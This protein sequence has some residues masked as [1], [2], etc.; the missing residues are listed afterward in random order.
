MNIIRTTFDWAGTLY[1][2]W[3]ADWLHVHFLIRTVL[4]LLAVWLIIFLSAQLLHYVIIPLALMAY[5]HGI[6]RAWNFLFVETPQEWLYLRY[7]SKDDHKHASLYSRLCDTVKK[8]RMILSHTKYNGMIYRARKPAT[9]LMVICLVTS[10]L[11]LSAFGLHQEY[12]TPVL[13]IVDTGQAPENNE[14]AAPAPAENEEYPDENLIETEYEDIELEPEIPD[15]YPPGTVS[16][17]SW[18]LDTTI[19]LSL[20]E[21]GTQGARLRDGPGIA[22]NTVIEIL[23]D[24]AQ[25]TYLHTFVPDPYVNGLYWLRVRTSGGTEGYISS[26]L[27]EGAS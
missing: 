3:F 17:A 26:Q 10:T 22:G 19:T 11:W 18:P 12:A 8:N 21:Q 20:T 4:L 2:E 24:D 15:T 14:P 1:S 9:G 16:P 27:V 5:Y 25:L 7:H 6:F 13:A 23:W